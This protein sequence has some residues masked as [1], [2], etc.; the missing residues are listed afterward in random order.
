M[1]AQLALALCLLPAAPQSVPTYRAAFLDGGSAIG[2]AN[3]GTCCGTALG[4]ITSTAAIWRPDGQL[5]IIGRLGTEEVSEAHAIN[6]AGTL[7]VGAAVTTPD[8]FAVLW[9]MRDG[10]VP[11]PG[12]HP[13]SAIDVNDAGD[14]IVLSP[15]HGTL[16]RPSG[17]SYQIGGFL[18]GLSNDGRVA[19]NDPVGA[20]RW[21]V[22]GGYEHLHLPSGYIS[23]GANGIAG[24]GTVAGALWSG[25]ELV[26]ALWSPAGVA[27]P[28][29]PYPSSF[30]QR[31][32]N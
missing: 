27:Q 11:L 12:A 16:L 21:T 29:K 14:V 20:F 19:G 8:T 18:V 13:S 6:G 23:A 26:G 10:A 9:S 1:L 24:D 15:G 22:A 28:P 17:R 2:I 5:E 31:R 25:T 3:D 7:V 4:A 30:S 32:S